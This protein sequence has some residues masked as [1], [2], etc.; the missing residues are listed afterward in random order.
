MS[1]KHKTNSPPKCKQ[2]GACCWILE[3]GQYKD[4]RWLIRYI[5]ADKN[6]FTTRCAIYKHRLY[7]IIGKNQYCGL[8]N[9]QL[10]N[11]PGCPFN[12]DKQPMHPSVNSEKN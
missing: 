5:G 11:Y 12:R 4:C 9:R 6:Q 1:H 8:R 2:C 3:N 7:S 10:Y